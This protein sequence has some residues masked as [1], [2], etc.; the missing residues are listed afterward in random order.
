MADFDS[1]G[2]YSTGEGLACYHENTKLGG[3]YT[4]LNAQWKDENDVVTSD[5]YLML[6]ADKVLGIRANEQIQLNSPHGY[7]FNGGGLMTEGHVRPQTNGGANCGLSK[8]RWKLMYCQNPVNVSS[9][10]RLKR[11]IAPIQNAHEL[12]MGLKPRQYRMRDV[13]LSEEASGAQAKVESKLHTGF[14]AQHVL[15]LA[16]DWAAAD[17][18]DPD[19]LG[20]LYEE[21]LAPLVQVVQDQQ[22]RIEALEA[23]L[24]KQGQNLA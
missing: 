7:R 5:H 23:L 16:P 9:D 15:E 6:L 22:K 19:N 2:D 1:L 18:S 12:I 4:G 20:M 17:G 11:D 3:L 10:A 24:E 13:D 21:I 8:W 14:I